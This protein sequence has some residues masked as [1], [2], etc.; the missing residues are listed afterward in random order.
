[1]LLRTLSLL[2]LIVLC[3]ANTETYMLKVPR[4]FN[5]SP[6]PEPISL[7]DT[8]NRNILEL[9][10]THS[11]LINYPIESKDT[12]RVQTVNNLLEIHN[13]NSVLAPTR[14]LLV[15]LNN[16]DDSTYTSEDLLNIKL[17]WPATLPYDFTLSHYFCK[18][19]EIIAGIPQEIDSFDVYLRIDY[20]FTAHTFDPSHLHEKDSLQFQLYITKLPISWLPIPLE[21]YEYLMYF[22]DLGIIVWT[23]TP[24]LYDYLVKA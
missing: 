15:K 4:Y 24:Y 7:H 17:C 12:Q 6:H 18:L 1:M 14:T 21:L 3:F 10:D 9:N 11:L 5:I 19:S 13:Y 8:L 2:L 16:Y 20:Q 22:V 23:M